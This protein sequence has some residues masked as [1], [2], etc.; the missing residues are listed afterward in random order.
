MS[1]TSLTTNSHIINRLL[2]HNSS[3]QHVTSSSYPLEL[4]KHHVAASFA[5]TCWRL[6][7]LTL[8]W[9]LLLLLLWVLPPGTTTSWMPWRQLDWSRMQRCT[10]LHTP[11][12]GRC[13][14]HQF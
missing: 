10:T 14:N 13:S 8:P 11:R 4:V 12:H 5:P 1:F 9:P 7:P 2:L 3:Q 6:L